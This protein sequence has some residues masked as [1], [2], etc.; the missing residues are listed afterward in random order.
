MKPADAIGVGIFLLLVLALF[1]AYT[2]VQQ[3]RRDV[4]R[5]ALLDKFSSAQD[6]GAFLQSA[7]GRQFMADLS[8]ST[9]AGSVLS[10]VQKGIVLLGLGFGFAGAGGIN[11]AAP[12]LG[13]GLIIGFSGV[14]F[15]VSALVTYFLS[16]AL[17]L[18]P[19]RQ[20]N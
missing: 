8:T 7:G 2:Y 11:S 10:S 19:K 9:A 4:M 12:V 20:E 5:R 18:M 16:K 15:L 3:S 14:A 13:I 1:L 17:G 6:L